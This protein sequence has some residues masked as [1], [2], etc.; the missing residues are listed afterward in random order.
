MGVGR[1]GGDG[2]TLGA[3]EAVDVAVDRLASALAD[4]GVAVVAPGRRARR[5]ALDRAERT[6]APLL[7]PVQLRRFLE[8]V[9]LHWFPL[10]PLKRLSTVN[11]VAH[12]RAVLVTEGQPAV[13]WPLAVARSS[14]LAVEL[15]APDGHDGD[16]VVFGGRRGDPPDLHAP[17]L[18]Q[19]V[20]SWADAVTV[21]DCRRAHGRVFL[22]R[23]L[24]ADRYARVRRH[25][26]PHP[27]Y[28]REWRAPR[29]PAAWPQRWRTELDRVDV[30]R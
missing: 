3:P 19:L 24:A 5:R 9:D 28:G 12:Q 14:F 26:M 17:D 11:R 25:A 29:D 8:L 4:V 6:V 22:R 13:L 18:A 15:T 30:G 10:A 20:H 2:A 16:A 27:V 21:R 1:I 7:L 23:Q